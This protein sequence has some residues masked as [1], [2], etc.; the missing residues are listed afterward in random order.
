M[1]IDIPTINT[2][3]SRSKTDVQRQ[4]GGKIDPFN[5]NNV[6]TAVT[7]ANANRVFDFYLQLQAALLESLP[8][9][10]EEY[11]TRWGNIFGI[12]ILPATKATG[13]LVFIG[14]V[15]NTSI[16]LGT[17]F[18]TSDGQ[19]YTSTQS[20]NY[21][22]STINTLDLTRQTN[23]TTVTT[24]GNHNFSTNTEIVSISGVT[25]STF[26]V[27]SPTITILNDTQFSYPN[28]GVNESATTQGIVTFRQAL[29]PVESDNFQ[30]ES[31]SVNKDFGT[32]ISLQ[33]PIANINSDGTVNISGVSGG[34]TQESQEQLRVRVLERIQNPVSHFNEADII[35]KIKEINGITRVFVFP[36]L[37]P[38]TQTPNVDGTV[39]VYFMRDNDVDPI[40]TVP[41]VAEAQSKLDEIIPANTNP[42]DAQVLAPT[43][44][45]QNFTISLL[46]PNT[47]TMQAAVIANLQAFFQEKPEVSSNV[48]KVAYDGA[49]YNT[50]DP[51]T[52]NTVSSF[53]VTTPAGDITALVGEIVVLGTVS[54]V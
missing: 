43:P 26:N 24:D 36:L 44:V 8:D 35:R 51:E 13:N 53:S 31:N 42:S 6:V 30:S 38:N 47:S 10:A 3:V 33:S 34:V 17:I 54:F 40:P 37:D 50:V 23:V 46:D 52:G 18:V 9:T 4:V 14:T 32:S 21:E 20:V 19:T 16:P 48:L 41:E 2:V 27:S 11:L 12:T 7:I 49:I 1:P 28:S 22:E 5:K 15:L 45:V 39:S 29:V 25:P